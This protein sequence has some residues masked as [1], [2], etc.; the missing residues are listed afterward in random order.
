M[1]LRL[2]SGLVAEFRLSS[3]VDSEKPNTPAEKEELTEAAPLQ[4]MVPFSCG[5]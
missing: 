2:A 1:Q 3:N 4:V 5:A